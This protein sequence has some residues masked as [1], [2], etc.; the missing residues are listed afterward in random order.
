MEMKSLV[1]GAPLFPVVVNDPLAS[2]PPARVCSRTGEE[3]E[4]RDV[5][6]LLEED[7]VRPK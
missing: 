6:T 5:S 7:F 4:Q 3:K 1:T 2:A